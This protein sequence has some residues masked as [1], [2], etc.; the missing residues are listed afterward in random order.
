MDTVSRFPPRK[1]LMNKIKRF[2]PVVFITVFIN[3]WFAS[4]LAHDP[5]YHGFNLTT[6]DPPFPAPEF[7]LPGLTGGELTLEDYKGKFV[8]L[9][10][11]ATWC[12]PCLEEMPSMEIIHQRYK[13][14]DFTVVAISSDEGG[15]TDIEPFI[16]KLGVT[17]PILMDADKAVSSVYGAVN[18]PLS[19]ILNPEGKVIAGSEGEREWDS[20]EAM[21]V[22]EEMFESP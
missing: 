7:Q 20:E 11:W 14:K 18:L 8:L 19:F 17:F 3:G 13:D 6:F 10:F 1:I 22:L 16:D 15:K 21:S 4:A 9:N 5:K 12:P 2:L